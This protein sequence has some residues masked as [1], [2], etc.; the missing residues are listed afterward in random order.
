M[1]SRIRTALFGIGV[2]AVCVAMA[3]LKGHHLLLAFAG[4]SLL[5]SIWSWMQHS[6]KPTPVSKPESN[7]SRR[8][9]KQTG[10]NNVYPFPTR[11]YV[12][13]ASGT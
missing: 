2:V 3:S 1:S 8:A 4:A 9:R 7:Y 11:S 12:S 5:G 13:D 10:P 6:R